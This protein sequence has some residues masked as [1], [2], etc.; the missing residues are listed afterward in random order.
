MI[1]F[2]IFK[3]KHDLT[4]TITFEDGKLIKTVPSSY[5]TVAQRSTANN[6]TEVMQVLDHLDQ[7]QAVGWGV[8]KAEADTVFVDTIDRIKRGKV[9]EGTIARSK[10]HFSWSNGPGVLMLDIDTP[11]SPAE[12]LDTLK[13]AF[14]TAT[15]PDCV[16]TS[17]N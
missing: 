11:H 4:K 8:H 15:G 9:V 6:L 12:A 14:L 2:S 7:K 5:V 13:K 1:S 17:R 10:D 16:K 3:G